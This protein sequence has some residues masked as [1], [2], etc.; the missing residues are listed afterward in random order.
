MDPQ[1]IGITATP[2]SE[3]QCT[4][5]VDRPVYPGGSWHFGSAESAEGSPL[6][7]R[8]MAIDSV[9]GVLVSENLVTVSKEGFEEWFPVAKQVGAIIRECLADESTKPIAADLAERIPTSDEMREKVQQVLDAEI[10]PQVAM[11]GGV[12]DLLDVK[13]NTLFIRMGGG[14]QG[15]GSATA[16]LKQGVEKILRE[17]IP[18]IGEILDTTDHAAGRNPYYAPM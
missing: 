14:C 15:C 5:T 17:R 4:F 7:E 8:I 2:Q 6:A 13:G 12:I 3:A 18:E 16:T 1:E 11:H 10:N 9:T